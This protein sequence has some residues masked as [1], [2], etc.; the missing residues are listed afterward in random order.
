MHQCEVLNQKTFVANKNASLILGGKTLGC[1]ESQ[2][3]YIYTHV[4]SI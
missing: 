3:T 4:E 1:I 2:V